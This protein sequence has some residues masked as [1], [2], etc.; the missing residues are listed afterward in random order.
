MEIAYDSDADAIGIYL[1][2]G[3]YMV[4]KEMGN[5]VIID[6]TAKGDIIG[7]EILD[8]SRNAGVKSFRDITVEKLNA[9]NYRKKK[10]KLRIGK[11][12]KRLADDD[13]VL[14]KEERRLL[15]ESVKHEKEG[16]LITFDEMDKIHKRSRKRAKP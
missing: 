10:M 9:K 11:P 3:K 7:I 15:D 8:A 16:K 5:G 12:R 6:Y 13:F 4:S 1:K 2:K 14:T